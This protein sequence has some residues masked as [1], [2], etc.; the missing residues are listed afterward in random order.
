[1]E[2]KNAPAKWRRNT[3]NVWQ[4]LMIAR[5]WKRTIVNTSNHRSLK[6]FLAL[7]WDPSFYRVRHVVFQALT[8]FALCSHLALMMPC[9]QKQFYRPDFVLLHYVHYSTVT[10]SA[11]QFVPYYFFFP[12]RTV[13]N[14]HYLHQNMKTTLDRSCG[15]KAAYRRCIHPSCFRES[16]NCAIRWRIGRGGVDSCK[17][18]RPRWNIL[19]RGN[20]RFERTFELPR[21]HPMSGPC[22]I[23]WCIAHEKCV[24]RWE[25]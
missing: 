5:T 15:R 19:S 10:V 2:S 16:K 20:V 8:D 3:T 1:M 9:A 18:H 12:S 7:W 6:D 4:R 14:S 22:R 11:S 17:N 25:R 23:W 24:P 21:G 13:S